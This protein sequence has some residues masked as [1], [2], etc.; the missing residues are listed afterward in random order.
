MSATFRSV[1]HP[2][3][4]PKG[5]VYAR[6][7]AGPIGA[8]TLPIMIGATATALLGQQIWGYLVWGLPA[9]LGVASIWTQFA[10][11]NTVAELHLRAGKCAVRSVHDVLYDRSLTWHP[12]YNVKGSPGEIELSVGWTARVC[13]QQDWPEFPELRSAAQQALHSNAP[14]DI[15]REV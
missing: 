13:S 3:D 9:A 7:L 4:R 14:M 11:S 6:Q 1:H 12:L 2:A 10:L 8:C 5:L 15:S